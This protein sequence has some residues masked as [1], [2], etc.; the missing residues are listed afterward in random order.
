M[1]PGTAKVVGGT[2]IRAISAKGCMSHFRC[3]RLMQIQL[4]VISTFCM[5]RRLQLI[6]CG[7]QRRNTACKDASSRAWTSH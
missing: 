3:L 1:I 7:V 5:R 2:R 4:G 6:G